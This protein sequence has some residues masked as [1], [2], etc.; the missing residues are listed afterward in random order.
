MQAVK[1]IRDATGLGVREA[2]DLVE[3]AAAGLQQFTVDPESAESL[4][5][6][7]TR[8]G[9]EAIAVDRATDDAQV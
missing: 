3:G 5:I 4:I 9:L 1:V 6:D 8:L 2:R 7:L